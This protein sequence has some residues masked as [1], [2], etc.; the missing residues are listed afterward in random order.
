MQN[1]R[2]NVKGYVF[3]HAIFAGGLGE[4]VIVDGCGNINGDVGFAVLTPTYGLS[5]ASDWFTRLI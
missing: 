5:R 1:H 3:I 2:L 4:C